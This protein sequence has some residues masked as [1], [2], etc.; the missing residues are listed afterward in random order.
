[1][2]FI[3]EYNEKDIEEEMLYLTHLMYLLVTELNKSD[4]TE[5]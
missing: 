2:G 5:T 4:Y 3:Y 1:M